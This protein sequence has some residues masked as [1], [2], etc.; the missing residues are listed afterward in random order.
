MPRAPTENIPRSIR[1]VDERYS[2]KSE[3]GK[4]SFGAVF[5]GQ[6]RNTG[7]NVALKFESIQ[8]RSK[9]LEKEYRL[10]REFY[11]RARQNDVL[12]RTPRVLYFGELQEY[13]FMSMTLLGPSL[14]NLF[15]KC[16]RKFT[17]RTV[18]MLGDQ[19]LSCMQFVHDNGY[20]H[21]DLKPNNFCVGLDD[22][23]R[24]FV[25]VIDFGLAK[26]Y[27]LED[28]A[29][30]P[31]TEGR[32]MVG[33]ARYAPVASH[34]GREQG[35]RDE[36]ESLL[37][38]LVYFLKGKLPWQ[39]LPAKNHREKNEKITQTKRTT[40]TAQ[41]CE[42]LPAEFVELLRY[43]RHLKFTERPNYASMRRKLARLFARKRYFERP[44][45][46]WEDLDF[47]LSGL[48]EY[49]AQ[50]QKQ[51]AA[52][53]NAKLEIVRH[54]R[55]IFTNSRTVNNVHPSAS[56]TGARSGMTGTPQSTT[57]SSSSDAGFRMS[58]LGDFL[59]KIKPVY[60]GRGVAVAPGEPL[61]HAPASD[62]QD[63]QR[64][65]GMPV[66]A[67]AHAARVSLRPL[68]LDGGERQATRES[69]ARQDSRAPRRRALPSMEAPV[70]A[71]LARRSSRHQA[72][73]ANR[74]M[75]M[76]PLLHDTRATSS[77][78]YVNAVAHEYQAQRQRRRSSR[79]RH[80]TKPHAHH[81][82]TH[83]QMRSCTSKKKKKKDTTC[84]IM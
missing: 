24:N 75:D 39:G 30:I 57:T 61:L 28:G 37:F 70:P 58:H 84:L 1:V 18:L 47:D 60:I 35:R 23:E 71:A 65:Q 49:D 14:E 76:E 20:L 68:R 27:L 15:E 69:A 31:L 42:G 44:L 7:D 21:R 81:T 53:R 50:T 79:A 13:N 46:D 83:S 73:A 38:I 4:G 33:T 2:V 19:M 36:L 25:Y 11:E 40:T 82:R 72:A 16:R 43:V 9:Q 26:P 54:A 48:G 51:Q 66:N 78:H 77:G 12:L 64:S 45:F 55:E 34:I 56:K 6:S 59:E 62:T 5:L 63:M 10:F 22:N 8:V 17:L 52:A 29:H 41:L 67:C 80:H 3:L 32:S 74:V